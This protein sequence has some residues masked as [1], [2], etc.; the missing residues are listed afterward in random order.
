MLTSHWWWPET[1]EGKQGSVC[2]DG[3]QNS[4]HI[5]C[6]E[7]A[8]WHCIIY[9]LYGMYWWLAVYVGPSGCSGR[10]WEL[11]SRV[12]RRARDNRHLPPWHTPYH[13][14]PI[15]HLAIPLWLVTFR[16]WKNMHHSFRAKSQHV[17]WRMALK[18]GVSAL[19]WILLFFMVI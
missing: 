15:W 11:I 13:L 7:R 16:G 2:W 10:R 1:E 6:A 5:R 4:T 14:C 3:W 17:M 9:R 8:G 12:E 18:I 19:N